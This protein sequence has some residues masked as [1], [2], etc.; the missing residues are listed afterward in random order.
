MSIGAIGRTTVKKIL[1]TSRTLM[2][3]QRTRLTLALL[4]LAALV[5]LLGT[6]Q[7]AAQE[8]PAVEPTAAAEAAPAAPAA[9][10]PAEAAAAPAA[11][12]YDKGDIAWMLVSTLLVLMMAVPGLALFYGGMV[13]SKNVLSVSMQ[14][15]VT[16]SLLSVLYAIYGYSLAF[17]GG[18]EFFGGF[19]RTFLSGM[20]DAAG[21][22]AP[23]ATFSKGVYIPEYL[24]LSLIHISEPTRLL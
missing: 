8:T 15:F 14:V 6:H 17:T 21:N 9:A 3:L 7:A 4:V 20:L 24:Y 1:A 22:L 12:V 19:G 11:P 13:R 16:F 5:M 10:A 2:H 23:A 18:N